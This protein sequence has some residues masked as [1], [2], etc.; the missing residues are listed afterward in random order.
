MKKLLDRTVDWSG[1]CETPQKMLPHF[2]S[3]VGVIEEAIQCPAGAAGQVR[4]R[5]SLGDEGLTAR[6]AEREHLGAQINH[7]LL[8]TKNDYKNF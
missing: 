4:P 1:R 8:T 7:S 3:C 2:F 6:P 5:W